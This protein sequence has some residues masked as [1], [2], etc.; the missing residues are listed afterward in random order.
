MSD[1]HC[2]VC[3]GPCLGHGVPE[4]EP[5]YVTIA[6]KQMAL[7]AGDEFPASLRGRLDAAQSLILCSLYPGERGAL[8]SRQVIAA[9]IIGWEHDEHSD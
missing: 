5:E 7:A 4:R 8:R 2:H 9:I 6:R 1:D 3:N